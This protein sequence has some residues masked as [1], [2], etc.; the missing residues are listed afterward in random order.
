MYYINR[1][2]IQSRLIS[3][4]KTR[5]PDKATLMFA[6]RVSIPASPGNTISAPP[7]NPAAK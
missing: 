2:L 6:S 7:P 5:F 4:Q 3:P 1:K